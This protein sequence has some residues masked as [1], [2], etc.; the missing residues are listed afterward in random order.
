MH[1][2]TEG[3][4][5]PGPVLKASLALLP[6]HLEEAGADGSIVRRRNPDHEAE[7]RSS[8]G[9]L[10]EEGVELVKAGERPCALGRHHERGRQE[11]E[12]E[13]D[14]KLDGVRQRQ[15]RAQN[16]RAHGA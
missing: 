1:V 9:K 10:R 3:V 8:E 5:Q 6:A 15:E 2:D 14:E 13:G 4:A 12:E 16:A 11:G 7:E